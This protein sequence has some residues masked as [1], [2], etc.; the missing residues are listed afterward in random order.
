MAEMIRSYCSGI[1]GYPVGHPSSFRETVS[2]LKDNSSYAEDDLGKL[3][4]RRKDII[5]YTT[6]KTYDASMSS[7]AKLAEM[8][9]K[10]DKICK[11][12]DIEA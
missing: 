4:R 9:A 3:G 7:A 2:C 5:D 12:L 8:D 1:L 11:K 6:L 10:L